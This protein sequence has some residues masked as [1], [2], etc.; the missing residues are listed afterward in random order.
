MPPDNLSLL[1]CAKLSF[2]GRVKMSKHT[3]F[4][5]TNLELS[6]TQRIVLGLKLG[7]LWA[8][9]LS[10]LLFIILPIISS[11]LFIVIG[12][13]TILCISVGIFVNWSA[14]RQPCPS[15]GTIF[16]VMPTGSH[17]PNCGY[18]A[19][20]KNRQVISSSQKGGSSN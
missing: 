12:I 15:C 4:S 7:L 5:D 14:T 18:Q 10:I 2:L 9:I 3:R 11:F 6:I 16:I 19:R 20:A 1:P 8:A 13:I 17:C